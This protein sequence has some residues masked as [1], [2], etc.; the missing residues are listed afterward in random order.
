MKD[1]RN[2]DNISF[3]DW[4]LSKGGTRAIIQRIPSSYFS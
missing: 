2:L 4:F 3:S 1:I